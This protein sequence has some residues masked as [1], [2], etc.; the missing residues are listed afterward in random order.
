[1][2]KEEK[3]TEETFT[4]FLLLL[5]PFA[6]HITEEVW[7]LLGKKDSIHGQSWPE[8]NESLLKRETIFLVVQVNGKV[9]DKVEVKADIS[10]E[11]AQELA[12]S[13][14]RVHQWLEGKKIRQV[15]FVAG[16]LL[17]IVTEN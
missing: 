5:A 17:N 6:P 1:M 10:K 8:Y 3:V 14:Q 16:K 7:G 9:R 13:R 2:E 12:Q 4:T 11:Q 15:V